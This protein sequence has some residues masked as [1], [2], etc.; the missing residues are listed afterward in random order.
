MHNAPHNDAFLDMPRLIDDA[1]DEALAHEDASRFILWMRNQ[2]PDYVIDRRMIADPSSRQLLY[3]FAGTFGRSL[4]NAIPLPGHGFRPQPIPAPGRNDF[5]FCGSGKKYKHC[6]AQVDREVPAPDLDT[7][8]LW[9]LVWER[10]SREQRQTAVATRRIP[11]SA[12]IE[13]AE[14]HF[15]AGAYTKAVAVIE[16]LFAAPIERTG[17]AEDFA[18]NMLFNCYDALGHHK[19]KLALLTRITQLP[20]R[21]PLRSGGWQRLATVL[22]DAGDV[23]GAWDAFRHAQQDDPDSPFIGLLETQLLIGESRYSEAQERARFWLKRLKKLGIA[24]NEQIVDY[25]RSV[26]DNALAASTAIG[27]DL[28]DQAGAGLHDWLA[29]A[30]TRQIIAYHTDGEHPTAPTLTEVL[31]EQFRGMG[32]P[33]KEIKKAIAAYADQMSLVHKESGESEILSG[34]SL[35]L[36]PPK[37]IAKLEKQWHKVYRLEKPFSTHDTPFIDD[38]DPWDEDNEAQWTAFL[39][40]HP[41]AF[42][43]LDIIDDLV[44]ALLL[45]PQLGA[46]WHEKTLLEPLLWRAQ[47]IVEKTLEGIDS[48][49]LEWPHSENRPA[50]RSLARQIHIYLLRHDRAQASQIAQYMLALNP[51]DNHGY[52][53]LV[54]NEYLRAGRDKEAIALAE[55]YPDDMFCEISYGRAL[56]LYR[57]GRKND[58]DAALTAATAGLPSV[59]KYLVK[60]RVSKPKFSDSEVSIGSNDQAWIYRSEMR[61]VWLETPGALEWLAKGAKK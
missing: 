1:V 46:T 25:F 34:T 27:F 22:L 7:A 36:R 50:L 43:S 14:N 21:S 6:C 51:R 54:I 10:L 59:V 57:L 55:H 8:E 37:A 47:A 5:C 39:I 44:T 35:V 16:P 26:A 30:A 60:A 18:L 13:I 23:A 2:L 58:A 49:I 3:M 24:E 15:D 32:L 56:A 28:S 17:D 33:A 31:T 52:R 29:N 40:K 53:A 38:Y 9:P 19:K 48:P 11:T 12:L 42:D 41:E 45:H 4:W 61:D 20:R